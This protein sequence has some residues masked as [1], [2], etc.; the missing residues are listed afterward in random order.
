MTQTFD[1]QQIVDDGC[2]LLTD[3]SL[4]KPLKMKSLLK[5]LSFT[6]VTYLFNLKT[7]NKCL[8]KS[9]C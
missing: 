9:P 5:K 4:E 7:F 3:I 1:N 6:F 2:F 8:V